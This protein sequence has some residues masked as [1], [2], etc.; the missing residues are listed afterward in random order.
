MLQ[1]YE[2]YDRRIKECRDKTLPLDTRLN[3]FTKLLKDYPGNLVRLCEENEQSTEIVEFPRNS[4]EEFYAE[5]YQ[6][7]REEE[8]K[9]FEEDFKK[10]FAD[11]NEEQLN[12]LREQVILRRVGLRTA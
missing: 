4:D 9:I 10:Q 2:D 5:L 3:M 7:M 12:E 11:L 6:D 8:L 1:L